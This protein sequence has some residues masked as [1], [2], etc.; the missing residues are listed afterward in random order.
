MRMSDEARVLSLLGP[1]DIVYKP[2]TSPTTVLELKKLTGT[3]A[4]AVY[5][6]LPFCEGARPLGRVFEYDTP[7]REMREVPRAPID[8]ACA[9][10]VTRPMRVEIR[11]DPTHA[12]YWHVGPYNSGRW[13]FIFADAVVAY[14]VPDHGGFRWPGWDN[15]TLRV[16]YISPAGWRT[17]SPPIRVD[18]TKPVV[19]FSR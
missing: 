12:W 4:I 9:A 1:N 19:A 15:F 8:R 5:D 6:E 3:P 13:T 10:I 16:R 2:L 14:D 7:R 11:F 18:G 17:Y